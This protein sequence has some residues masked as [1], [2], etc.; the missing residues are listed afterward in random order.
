M[1]DEKMDRQEV[2]STSE[3]QQTLMTYPDG[4][5]KAKQ[6]FNVPDEMKDV[7]MHGFLVTLLTM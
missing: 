7:M 3:C 1:Q 5:E 4:Y 2:A 6:L